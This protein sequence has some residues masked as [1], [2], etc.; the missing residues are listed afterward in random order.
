MLASAGATRRSDEARSASTEWSMTISHLSTQELAERW[1]ISRR[2]LDR[3]RWVGAGPVF[4]KLGGRVVYR[5]A[6]IEAFEEAQ[7]HPA[8]GAA[9]S[10][11]RLLRRSAERSAVV[12]RRHLPELAVPNGRKPLAQGGERRTAGTGSDLGA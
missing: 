9:S 3:W 1:N 5:L 6:D 12:H 2:T 11:H 4:L 7:P 8:Q 10:L